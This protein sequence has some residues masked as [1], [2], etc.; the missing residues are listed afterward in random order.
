MCIAVD[1]LFSIFL[2]NQIMS[3]IKTKNLVEH[4][5]TMLAFNYISKTDLLE[6]YVFICTKNKYP[7]NVQF[8]LS[9]TYYDENDVIII[10]KKTIPL[11]KNPFTI[12]GVTTKDKALKIKIISSNK[13]FNISIEGLKS[14]YEANQSIK[15]DKIYIINLERKTERKELMI[16]KLAEQGI[17]NYEFFNAIDGKL[18]EIQQEFA[19]YKKNGSK[20]VSAGHFACLKSHTA[21]LRKILNNIDENVLI[22]ED[23]VIFRDDFLNKLST[24][25]IPQFDVLYFGGLTRENKVYLNGWAETKN[26]MGLYAYMVNKLNI[27]KILD[28]FESCQTYCDRMMVKKIQENNEY[29]VILL[30]DIIYT[31]LDDTDTSGKSAM[32]YRLIENQ[33]GQL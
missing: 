11:S 15:I 30:N 29:R 4:R 13:Q 26:A 9:S 21:V 6:H 8:K 14:L 7:T 1:D 24:Y 19:T 28:I 25:K 23:D 2:S 33:M 31:N 16:R 5:S 17:T 18:P 32:V 12:N 3:Y 22:L 20:F 10:N 27:P